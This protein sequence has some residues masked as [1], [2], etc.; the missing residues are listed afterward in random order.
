[1]QGSKEDAF[2]DEGLY[3]LSEIIFT[4]LFKSLLDSYLYFLYSSKLIYIKG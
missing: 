3:S 4:L 2:C 1:M